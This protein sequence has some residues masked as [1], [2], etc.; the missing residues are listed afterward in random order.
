MKKSILFVVMMLSAQAFAGGSDVGSVGTRNLTVTEGEANLAEF[1]TSNNVKI[2]TVNIAGKMAQKL[3]VSMKADPVEVKNAIQDRSVWQKTGKDY[4][5]MTG[6]YFAD[7]TED[8]YSCAMSVNSEE[9]S[10]VH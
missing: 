5:C 7:S 3:Y 4:S 1:V 8:F 10:I 2:S 9:G 6:R